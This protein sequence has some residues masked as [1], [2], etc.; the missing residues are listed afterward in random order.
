MQQVGTYGD[1]GFEAQLAALPRY[2]PLAPSGR[3]SNRGLA[4]ASIAL[5]LGLLAFFWDTLLGH[6]QEEEEVVV[7]RVVEE[8][9][10]E[11]EPP[12][13]RRKVLAQ[14]RV[15]ASVRRFKQVAQPEVTE[16][17]PV[18]VLD[19]VQRVQVERTEVTEAPKLVKPRTVATRAVSAFAEAPA[20]VQPAHVSDVSGKV[21]RVQSA[22]A[23]AG[24]RKLLAAGPVTNARAADVNAPVVARGVI[25]DTA[26]EGDVE[27]ARVADLERGTSDRAFEGVGD[28]GLLAG[29][30][31]DCETDPVCMAYLQMIEDRVYN[32]WLI[33][34]DLGGGHVRL[35]FRIDRGGSAHSLSIANTSDPQL[36]ETCVQAFRHASPFP[37]PPREI[38]Y[39]VGKPILATFNTTRVEAN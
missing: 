25:S 19:Q 2:D 9:R 21:A 37:P 32:R 14:R 4:I 34:R 20:Q 26:I 30:E 29:V 6:I 1:P 5:H 17:K 3:R 36:G 7:V 12:K 38:Q 11:P 35:R 8:K 10:P 27:G 31:R 24:P 15:D 13:L 33:P 18:S 16:V 22:R 39:I 23:S 28:R